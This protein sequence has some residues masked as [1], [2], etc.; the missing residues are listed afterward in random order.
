MF[1]FSQLDLICTEA[2]QLETT[3]TLMNRIDLHRL[4]QIIR[5]QVC[6]INVTVTFVD[7]SVEVRI[8]ND[9][10]YLKATITGLSLTLD[11]WPKLPSQ[12]LLN[13][14]CSASNHSACTLKIL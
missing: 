1:T 11:L 14:V 3:L 12:K 2:L 5:T 8:V 7:P 6:S 9:C 4:R 10:Y 13:N